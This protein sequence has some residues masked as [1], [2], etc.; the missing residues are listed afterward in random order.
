MAAKVGLTGGI[1]SGKSAVAEAFAALGVTVIDAD[2]IARRLSQPGGAAFDAIAAQFGA[3]ILDPQGRIDRRRLGRMVFASQ[4]KR[5][6]LE[7]ILHPP[8]RAEMNAR[9]R[10]DARPY[11]ILDI[12]L[13]VESGWHLD[14]RRV[15]VVACARDERMRRIEQRAGNRMSRADI[16]RVMNSQVN[17]AARLKSADDVIDN[18]G[19]IDELQPQVRRLHATYTAMFS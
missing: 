2:R 19:D 7:A 4:Q 11:C 18:N 14:M 16:E 15:L 13:L 12:P 1:G 8:I 3:E 17:D 9:A 6:Q 5:R 10:D